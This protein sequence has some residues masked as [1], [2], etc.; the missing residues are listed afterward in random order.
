MRI[1]SKKYFGKKSKN[2]IEKGGEN[3]GNKSHKKPRNT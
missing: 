2:I 3:M 1:K